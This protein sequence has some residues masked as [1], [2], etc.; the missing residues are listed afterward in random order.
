MKRSL[1]PTYAQ[2]NTYKKRCLVDDEEYDTHSQRNTHTR[3]IIEIEEDEEN[4]THSQRN[5]HTRRIIE[6]EEDEEN[7][8][9]SPTVE[10]FNNQI[11]TSAW[12]RKSAPILDPT[13]DA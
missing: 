11:G 1:S 13:N 2:P 9:H 10:V 12:Y 4:D 3:R 6:I 5:T 7:D 8:T